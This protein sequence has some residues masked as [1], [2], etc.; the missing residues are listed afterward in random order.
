[1]DVTAATSRDDLDW[2]EARAL[3][4]L[5][6]AVAHLNH[7]SYGAVPL[8]VLA[9]QDR[10]GRQAEGNPNKFFRRDLPELLEEARQTAAAFLAADP[11]ATVFVP[12]ATTGIN[13]ALTSIGLSPGDEVLVTDHAY[14]AVVFAAERACRRR[15]A[16]LVV[17][18]VDLPGRDPGALVAAVLDAVTP[19]TRAAIVEHIASPTAVVFPAASLVAGLAE[20]EVST[21]VDAAHVPGMIEAAVEEVGADFWVGNFHKW[22][23]SPRGAAALC[24]APA[25]RAATEP[26]VVSWDIGKGFPQS[27]GWLGTDDY[28][29][30]LC[31]PAALEFMRSLGWERVR[32][33]N[34][35]L[36]RFGRDLLAAALGE[37]A[38]VPDAF[39]EAMTLVELPP[40]AADTDEDARALMAR[41]ADELRCEVAVSVWRG[42]GYVRLSAQAYNSPADYE[43]LASGLPVLLA[44]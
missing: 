23:C 36:A 18:P 17:A 10:L 43:R 2:P 6:P 42:R 5:D 40:G 29:P 26:L 15:G 33:H 19:R 4:P 16:E 31:V 1:M 37:A 27:F 20:R 22:A 14:G 28:I 8:A 38:P 30:Y 44:R 21:I 35:A 34:R 13:A 24:V 12:N 25:W 39:S 32:S 3:W 11:D 41:I 9:E 7:G